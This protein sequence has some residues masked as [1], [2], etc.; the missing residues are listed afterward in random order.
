MNVQLES[1]PPSIADLVADLGG[2]PLDRIRLR[3]SPG[4]AALADVEANKNCEL[5]DGA[6]VEKP[7]GL[8]E[9]FIAMFIGSAIT[10]FAVKQKLGLVAGGD[11]TFRL[12]KK[13]VRLP[14][15]AF[16]SWERMPDGRVPK[17]PI[18]FLAPDLAVEVLSEGNT[19]A[20]MKRKRREYFKR[21][22]RLVWIVDRFTKTVAVYT[23]PRS[24]RIMT[25][26]DTLEG[27]D[28]LPGFTL[29]VGEIFASV[30]N[31]ES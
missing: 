13:L 25:E 28:V 8:H 3:P 29:S 23:S 14:D 9:A 15:V 2:I 11:G 22:V 30:E 31:R 4:H 16:V 5:I 10:Q 27:G 18:P 1:C 24:S 12:G 21:G 26:T 7:M 20:E 6:L 19:V 17:E